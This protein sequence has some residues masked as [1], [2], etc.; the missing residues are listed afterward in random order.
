MLK[1]QGLSSLGRAGGPC[2]GLREPCRGRAGAS[3]RVRVE[4]VRE[5]PLV[6]GSLTKPGPHPGGPVFPCLYLLSD[7]HDGREYRN[8]ASA[9]E[10]KILIMIANHFFTY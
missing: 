3:H 1:A 4:G 6:G 8:G 9:S 10:L 7:R 2:L 5:G